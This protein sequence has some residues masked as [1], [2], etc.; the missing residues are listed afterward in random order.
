M[1]CCEICQ[2]GIESTT[3]SHLETNIEND[4]SFQQFFKIS[5]KWLILTL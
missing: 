4:F 1:Q 2:D 3:K 5:S